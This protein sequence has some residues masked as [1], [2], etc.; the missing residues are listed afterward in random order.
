VTFYGDCVKTREDFAPNFSGKELDVAS[1]QRTVSHFRFTWGFFTKI[2]DDCRPPP[3]PF[4]KLGPLRL[5]SVSPI[6]DK[7]ERSP[8][9]HNL[10]DRGIIAGTAEHPHRTQLPGCVFKMA[11]ALETVDTHGRGYFEGDG[12]CSAQS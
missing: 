8:F 9:W 11:E 5:F 10:G 3:T 12:G 7:T 2:K 6:E 4:A 1:R